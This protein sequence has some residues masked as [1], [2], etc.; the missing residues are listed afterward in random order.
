MVGLTLIKAE[1]DVNTVKE[2]MRTINAVE[3]SAKL[4]GFRFVIKKFII[5]ANNVVTTMPAVA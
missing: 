2:P 3:N 5:V 1:L 4:L